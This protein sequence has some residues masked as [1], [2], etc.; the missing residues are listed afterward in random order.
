MPGFLVLSLQ[1]IV[2]SLL[3]QKTDFGFRGFFKCRITLMSRSNV[4]FHFY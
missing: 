4:C 2:C 1:F 3:G